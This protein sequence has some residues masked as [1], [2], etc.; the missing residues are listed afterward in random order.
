[1]KFVCYSNWDQL[2]ESANALFEQG[3]KDSLFFTR[4]WFESVTAAALDD[5][6]TMLLACVVDGDKVKAIL[7][8]MQSAG[9]HSGGMKNAGNKTW[10]SLRHGFT[11]LYSVLLADDDQERVLSC[12]AEAVDQLAVNGLLLEPV[13]KDDGKINTL[14]RKLETSMS[15]LDVTQILAWLITT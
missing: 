10:Y 11:P 6:H 5:D 13:A 4:P 1:M 2:P 14:Q 7:P 8:L 15:N 12:L 3:E 9:V